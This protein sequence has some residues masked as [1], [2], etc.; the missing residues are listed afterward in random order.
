MQHT[1]KLEIAHSC[2]RQHCT[3]VGTAHFKMVQQC[4]LSMLGLDHKIS[5][6]KSIRRE[7]EVKD[8]IQEAV[9]EARRHLESGEKARAT[10]SF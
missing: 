9:N 7:L 4:R 1:S 2:K 10:A 6:G 5:C 3:G 8:C